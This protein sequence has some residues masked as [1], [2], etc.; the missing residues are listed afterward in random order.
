MLTSTC[1][2]ALVNLL[3]WKTL[4]KKRN[5]WVNAPS[6]KGTKSGTAGNSRCLKWSKNLQLVVIWSGKKTAF[7]PQQRHLNKPTLGL[8]TSSGVLTCQVSGQ[9]SGLWD[10]LTWDLTW[11]VL[12]L[13]PLTWDLTWPVLCLEPLTWDRDLRPAGLSHGLFKFFLFSSFYF[14]SK[15]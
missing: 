1:C 14:L 10:P 2:A 4:T 11:P 13:E 7:R 3:V 5:N 6:Y 15:N 9:V 12:F 8:S